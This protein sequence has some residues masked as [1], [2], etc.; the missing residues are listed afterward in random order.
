MRGKHGYASSHFHPD[1]RASRLTEESR[2][3]E[4]K[5]DRYTI[6]YQ[7]PIQV[8]HEDFES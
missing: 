3:A 5:F 7:A 4:C 1:A 2:F 6:L 8:H